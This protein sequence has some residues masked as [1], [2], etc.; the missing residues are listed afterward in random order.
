MLQKREAS[1][2]QVRTIPCDY[3]R[4]AERECDR[5][6]TEKICP[7]PSQQCEAAARDVESCYGTSELNSWHLHSYVKRKA[8]DKGAGAA[9]DTT[10]IPDKGGRATDVIAH[11][12]I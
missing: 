1:Q 11:S 5:G 7:P 9:D 10:C 8:P 4:M 2:N 6:K 12:Q 3:W